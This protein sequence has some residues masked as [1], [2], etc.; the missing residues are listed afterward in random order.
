MTTTHFETDRQKHKILCLQCGHLNS[1]GDTTC[2]DCA[3]R[4]YQRKPYSLALTWNY[5]VAALLFL[6]PAN[7]LTMMVTSSLGQDNR[8]TILQGI[9]YFFNSGEIFIGVVIFI[10]SIM[11]PIIKIVSLFFLL[12]VAHFKVYSLRLFALK[13]YRVIRYIGKYSLVDVY[14]VAVMYALVQYSNLAEIEV[15]G[16][17]A[18][19]ATAVILTMLATES[20]DA[21]IM[22]DKD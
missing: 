19:F 20:F 13:I 4:I 16:A 8:S 3:S 22:F 18:T 1:V 21:R 14:V 15:G 2:S 9:I 6:I 5:T 17:A 12:F 11:V 10:A 7:L